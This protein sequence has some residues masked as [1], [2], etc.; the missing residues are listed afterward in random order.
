MTATK[1]IDDDMCSSEGDQKI[2]N[3]LKNI[4][5][6]KNETEIRVI[7]ISTNQRSKM[8]RELHACIAK[9]NDRDLIEIVI[10]SMIYQH[11]S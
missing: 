4:A 3:G 6:A 8:K 1:T 2:R 11:S 5:I 10:P 7:E 9:N